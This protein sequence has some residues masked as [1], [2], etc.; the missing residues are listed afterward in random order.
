[1]RARRYLIAVVIMFI[2]AV[3]VMADNDETEVKED[4]L[5]VSGKVKIYAPADRATIS[6]DLA[7]T[8]S[9]LEKAF[10]SVHAKTDSIVTQLKQ[11]GLDESN[12]HTSFFR[13]EENEGGK[14]FL[15][16]KRD[17]KVSQEASV[18]TDKLELLEQIVVILSRN[19]VESISNI[20]FELTNVEQFKLKALE[21][22][23]TKAKQ[24]A[25]SMC[26]ILGVRTG[27]VKEITEWNTGEIFIRGGR[28]G[29]ASYNTIGE[30]MSQVA[31][32]GQ[33]A[34]LF[35]QEFSVEAQVNVVFEID[36]GEEGKE[37]VTLGEL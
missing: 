27:R 20:S 14:A 3:N 18:T 15:S 1:M 29:E 10:A 5:T 34:S 6:F 35:G 25:E 37:P 16:S 31:G 23:V 2:A 17:Y 11:I 28:A 26:A 13:S 12:L 7:G 33:S 19:K 24:K 21:D 4:L 32:S 22:A 36:N 8:G 30:V 9:S